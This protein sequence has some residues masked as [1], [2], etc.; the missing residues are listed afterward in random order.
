MSSPVDFLQHTRPSIRADIIRG[1]RF[2]CTKDQEVVIYRGI[3]FVDAD[4]GSALSER[5]LARLAPRAAKRTE[6]LPM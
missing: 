6:F 5:G 1:I 2:R 3:I 4:A